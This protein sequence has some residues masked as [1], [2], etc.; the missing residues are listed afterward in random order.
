MLFHDD[1][2]FAAIALGGARRM[3]SG[4]TCEENKRYE[5]ERVKKQRMTSRLVGRV[6]GRDTV[7]FVEGI[8]E[9]KYPDRRT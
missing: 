6:L 7:V 2:C 8:N 9:S 5:N 4:L 1:P 3:G